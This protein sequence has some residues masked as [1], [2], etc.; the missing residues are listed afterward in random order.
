[1][2]FKQLIDKYSFEEIIPELLEIWDKGNIFRFRQAHDIL[3]RLTP[4]GDNLSGVI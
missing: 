1:M 4:A 3:R 2:T